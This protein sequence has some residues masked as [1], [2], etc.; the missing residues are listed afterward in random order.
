LMLAFGFF[1]MAPMVDAVAVWK[2]NFSS[3]DVDAR[4]ARVL[5]GEKVEM[6]IWKKSEEFTWREGAKKRETGKRTEKI[7]KGRTIASRWPTIHEY[8]I[9]AESR[10]WAGKNTGPGKQS[11]TG[12]GGTQI[13]TDE[14]E[15]LAIASVNLTFSIISG[16]YSIPAKSAI[17]LM[18]SLGFFII[19][20]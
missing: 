20:S 18:F 12:H 3:T 1:F 4:D 19:S 11:Q 13:W 17:F 5:G 9:Q 10:I 14:V 8:W 7:L 16:V 6:G 2:P 15:I